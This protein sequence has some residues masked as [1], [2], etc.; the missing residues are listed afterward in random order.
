MSDEQTE[1]VTELPEQQS[2]TDTS[3]WQDKTATAPDGEKYIRT[4][5]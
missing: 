4:E 1:P 2:A 3:V 5:E